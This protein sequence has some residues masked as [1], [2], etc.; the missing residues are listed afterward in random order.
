MVQ[1][2]EVCLRHGFAAHNAVVGMV[3]GGAARQRIGQPL[4]AVSF[5]E[6]TGT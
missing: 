3:V 4:G 1:P 5:N 2:Q 6:E